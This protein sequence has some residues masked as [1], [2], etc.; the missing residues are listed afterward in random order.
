VVVDRF[1]IMAHFIPIDKKDSPTV[2]K[3]YLVQV[4]MYHGFPE[5]VVSDRD[6]IFTG[7]YFTD[8]DNF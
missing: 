3:V 5:D 1:T 8:L 2:A 7:Q 4:W 6:G